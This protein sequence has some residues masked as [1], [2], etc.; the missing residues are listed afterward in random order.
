MQNDPLKPDFLKDHQGII[1]QLEQIADGTSTP[2]AMLTLRFHRAL[3]PN[4][5]TNAHIDYKAVRVYLLKVPIK[6]PNGISYKLPALQRDYL[7]F[8]LVER[9]K[10]SGETW[11]SSCVKASEYL[12]EFKTVEPLTVRDSHAKM[13]KKIIANDPKM[14]QFC[15]GLEYEFQVALY[16]EG[17]PPPGTFV[18]PEF[19]R[20][21]PD[22]S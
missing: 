3:K 8:T 5:S 20:I 1:E 11:D 12:S 15:A 2:T 6:A 7:R 22:H 18:D 13:K 14:A 17:T 10:Q 19:L 21:A 16:L 4:A 9:Y